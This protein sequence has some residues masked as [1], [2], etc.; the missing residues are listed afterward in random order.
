M[1]NKQNCCW[2]FLVVGRGLSTEGLHRGHTHGVLGKG[3]RVD[4]YMGFGDVMHSILWCPFKVSIQS[5]VRGGVKQLTNPQDI[6]SN[7]TFWLFVFLGNLPSNLCWW[8]IV[9]NYDCCNFSSNI[10]MKSWKT[11]TCLWLLW[12]HEFW[13]KI[14]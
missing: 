13:T 14:D 3:R 6:T 8:L 1:W 5:E 10:H 4:F 11:V 7:S 2:E 9:G 12:W